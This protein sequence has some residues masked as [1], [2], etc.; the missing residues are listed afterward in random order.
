MCLAIA[1]STVPFHSSAEGQETRSEEEDEIREAIVRY[2]VD[3]WDMR[4]DVYFVEVQSKDPSAAF[5]RRF[6]DLPKPVKKK[7]AGKEKKDIAGFHVEDRRTKKRGVIFDQGAITRLGDSSVDVDGGYR[8][9][10]LC[11]ASGTYHVKRQE[12]RWKVTRF[13]ITFQS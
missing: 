8:C 12:G 1:L 11:M 2:Q 5:L 13:T 7:S 6:E 3:N 10:T 4:A 9:A